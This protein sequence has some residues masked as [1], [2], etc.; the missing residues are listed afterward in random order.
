LWDTGLNAL[1]EQVIT[2]PEVMDNLLQAILEEIER[3]RLGDIVP[4]ETLRSLLRMFTDLGL[5]HS[6]FE[7]PFLEQTRQFYEKEGME[8]S[9]EMQET[10]GGDA[11]ASFLKYA[12]DRIREEQERC[13]IGIGYI[14]ETT[15]KLLIQVAEDCLVRR[16][17]DVCLSSGFKDLIKD[18]RLDTLKRMYNLFSRVGGLAQLK[19][20]FSEYIQK[21]GAT[22]VVDAQ[23]DATMVPDLLNFKASLDNILEESFQKSEQF[24]NS[25]KESF[26]RFIN[27]RQNKP[28]EMIAKHVDSLLR[29]GKGISEEEVDAIL[30][31]CMTLFRFIQGKDVFE[32]FYKKDLAKRLLVGRSA[33]VDAEKSMLTKLKQEC[34]P[35]FTSKLE[36]MFKDMDISKDIMTSFK[37]SKLS[38]S[39][40]I[41][42]S[43]NVLTQGFWPTYVP[44]EVNLPDEMQKCQENFKQ[45]YMSKHTGRKLQWQHTLAHCTVKAS[46]PKGNK[47]LTLSLFQTIVL[48]LFNGEERWSY[49]DILKNIGLAPDELKKTLQSLACGKTRVLT[50]HPKGRD[51]DEA[52]EFTVNV[53]F[54]NPLFRVKVNTIQIKETVE[55]QKATSE[56]IVQDRQYQIDAAIVRIMKTR[57][58]VSHNALVTELLEQL[59]FAVN[60]ADLKKRIESLIDRSYM[61]RSA[62]DARYVA[63]LLY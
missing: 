55:E 36:G 39:L 15:R 47:E 58:T 30:D 8:K 60:G 57:K 17:L 4:K 14:D 48:L 59:R 37:G 7:Q 46:F 45:F 12:E 5:Y 38:E 49:S 20:A 52:D 62:E 61:E 6:V 23:R 42:F 28:G 25:M 11:V 35:V 41:D 53:D 13:M 63:V 22:L 2:K 34:G 19:T 40:D 24:G 44:V 51:V 21:E 3:D 26:E 18:D 54:E 1:R 56:I 31:K 32:A 10:D 9:L 50:K 33:S 43:V 27:K 16:H 29:Q